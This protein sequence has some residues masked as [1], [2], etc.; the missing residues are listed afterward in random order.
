[1]RNNTVLSL[2]AEV[3]WALSEEAVEN[4][5]VRAVTACLYMH[6]IDDFLN[7]GL[8]KKP[9]DSIGCNWLK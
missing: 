7:N 1:M 3:G 6:S 8:L 9:T 4:L 5:T 2:I